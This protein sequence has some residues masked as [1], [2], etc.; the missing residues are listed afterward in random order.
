VTTKKKDVGAKVFL[1]T[2]KTYSQS[3]MVSVRVSKMDHTGLI[4]I[5]PAVIINEAYFWLVSV[6]TFINK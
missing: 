2:R 1:C 6:T 4:F 3:L 5:D